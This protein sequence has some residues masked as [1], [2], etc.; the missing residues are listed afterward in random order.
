MQ[1]VLEW[2]Q[3]RVLQ[4]SMFPLPLALYVCFPS[5]IT[6]SPT[7]SFADIL[8]YCV[9]F[10]LRLKHVSVRI[11]SETEYSTGMKLHIQV[12]TNRAQMV[13]AA[14]SL[15]S[16]LSPSLSSQPWGE[17]GHLYPALGGSDP[18]GERWA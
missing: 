15:T 13:A 5:V 10:Q 7:M 6:F 17:W 9:F 18:I 11:V 2:A 4:V 8:V 14:Q 1:K 16:N 12:V 3:K